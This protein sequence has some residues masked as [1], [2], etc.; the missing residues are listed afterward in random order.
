MF[1]KNTASQKLYVYA[2]TPADGL[3]K[4]GDAAQITAYVGKDYGA[5]TV[6][7]D[8]TATEVDATN[9]P[10]FYLFDLT[11]AETNADVL[12]F[13]GKSSTSGVKV[14]GAPA[15]V[16]TMPTTGVLS[17]T[18]LGR[19]LVVD[20]SG[21]AD[22]N[23]VKIG[24]SGSG[25]AQ[26]AKDVGSLNI[27]SGKVLIQGTID[28]FDD[29]V[30]GAGKVTINA[31]AVT[32]IWTDTT[33][34]DFTA[35]LSV[36][37]SVMNGVS[38]GTGLTVAAVSGA[39]GSVTGAVGSVTGAVGSVT[40]NVGGNVTGSVGSVAAGG[41][42]ASSFAAGAI[43]ASAIAADAI[44]S[45]ELAATA[46][47]EIADAILDRATAIEGY[48]PRQAFRLILASLAAKLS[49]A[50]TTTV[51]IRDIADTKDRI[52]ATVDANGNRTA[53]TLDAT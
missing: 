20:A 5:A 19:T 37:K 9:A 2:Y 42:S 46:A 27:S 1:Y 21:L 49:G 14:L 30:D 10:G 34:S 35:A 39:V 43:D 11:Q 22:A 47:N 26:T 52:T 29:F 12:H 53:V 51:A 28:Q 4:T 8:T 41:I 13:S 45:S 25:T 44:G 15:V 16:F 23:T 48:T 50:A 40:G 17:P 32:A 6:L 18:T 24:P 31:A 36:G 7:G 3:P 33:A 38:L